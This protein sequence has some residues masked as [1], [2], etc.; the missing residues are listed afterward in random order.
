MSPNKKAG[1]L[2]AGTFLVLCLVL[3]WLQSGM[4]EARAIVASAAV[5]LVWGW[6]V[7]KVA[8]WADQEN[9]RR[10]RLWR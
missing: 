9:E 1:L 5:C 8:T 2:I 10:R 7:W 3:E 6:F 4:S